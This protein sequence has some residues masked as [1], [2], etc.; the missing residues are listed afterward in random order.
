MSEVLES[1]GKVLPMVPE[2]VG[3]DMQ[4]SLSSK[5]HVIGVWPAK[6]FALPG[7]VDGVELSLE[8]PA[9]RNII[10]VLRT[11][12]P[13]VSVLP[14]EMLGEPIRGILTPVMEDGEVVGVVACAISLKETDRILTASQNLFINLTQTQN[15]VEEV[16]GGATSLSE[17]LNKINRATETV[18]KQV[19][20]ALKCVSAIQ[21]NAARSNILALNG[22]IEAAR[23]GEAGRGFAVVAKEMGNFAR[24]SGSTAREI[25]ESL[26][27]V[28]ESILI[29]TGEVT[30]V[31]DVAMQQAASTQEMTAALS[32]ITSEASILVEYNQKM[33]Q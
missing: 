14:K 4:L 13:N 30:E 23:V 10:E 26:Q 22:S 17:K 27:E 5:T 32:D 19:A 15:A 33:N 7:A 31:N 29:I 1:L 12:K 3:V 21:S 16:A 6:S 11:G 28:S 18:T 9:Q 25:S 20:N 2:I 8:N 24:V